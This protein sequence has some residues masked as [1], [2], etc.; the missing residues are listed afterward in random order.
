[1]F[2]RI[3]VL[4]EIIDHIRTS[5]NHRNTIKLVILKTYLTIRLLR[6]REKTISSQAAHGASEEKRGCAALARERGLSEIISNCFR[7]SGFARASGRIKEAA[8][9]RRVLIVKNRS[10]NRGLLEV[11]PGTKLKRNGKLQG[12][13]DVGKRSRSK[14]EERRQSKGLPEV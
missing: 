1:M 4:H 13:S 7:A 8:S 11:R 2:D 12:R 5:I 3:R 9:A 14:Y 10:L 6:S